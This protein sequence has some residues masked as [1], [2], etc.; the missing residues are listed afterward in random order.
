MLNKL[1]PSQISAFWDSV[2]HGLEQSCPSHVILS[3]EVLNNYLIAAMSGTI[4][5]W[6][7]TQRTEEGVEY[8]GN[9]VT[10]VT[11]DELSDGKILT[12]LSLYLYKSAPTDIWEDAYKALLQF[13]EAND[14][15]QIIAFTTNPAV[16]QRGKFFNFDTSWTILSHKV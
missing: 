3:A 15:R 6:M 13:A 8:Y 11:A 7:A 9:I 12:I 2:K 16:V 4:Q 14:C 10:K 5:V 1:V